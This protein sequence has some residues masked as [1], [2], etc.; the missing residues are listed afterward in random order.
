MI[1][2]DQGFWEIKSF[3]GKKLGTVLIL[4][5]KDLGAIKSFLY[6]IP[7][8]SWFYFG[9][10]CVGELCG[11]CAFLKFFFVMWAE[12]VFIFCWFA[13]FRIHMF[14]YLY[15]GM[16]MMLWN[17]WWSLYFLFLSDFSSLFYLCSASNWIYGFIFQ[18]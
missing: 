5:D 18:L 1:S 3:L 16:M 14:I 13:T 8:Q 17:N 6:I 12:R 10:C 9:N 4:S 15:R 11:P 2:R 7:P